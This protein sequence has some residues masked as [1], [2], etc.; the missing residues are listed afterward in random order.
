MFSDYPYYRHYC[1]DTLGFNFK[2]PEM[3]AAFGRAQLLKLD[4]FASQRQWR[5]NYLHNHLQSLNDFL[6]ITL[7]PESCR[8][9]W[10]GFPLTLKDGSELNR[11]MFGDYLEECGIRHRPFF[12]GNITEHRPFIQY[13]EPHAWPVADKLMRDSLFIGCHPKMTKEDL[14]YIVEK[15]TSYVN[16]FPPIKLAYADTSNVDRMYS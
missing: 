4:R 15:I 2:L 3:N 12:A 8:V 9:S 14:D 13:K 6:P 1:Y 7:W 5:F 16:K 11:N 10:F